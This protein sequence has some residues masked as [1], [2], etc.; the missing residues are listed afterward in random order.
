MKQINRPRARI[1]L[2]TVAVAALLGTAG[3]A[4]QN[5]APGAAA[6]GRQGGAATP[7]GR[8]AQAPNPADADVR[9]LHVQGNVWLI[10][11]GFVNAAVQIGDEGVLVVD[12]LTEPLGAK[13]GAEIKR[14]AGDNPIR[15]VLNTHFHADHTGGNLKVAGAGRSIVGGNFAGQVGAA[16]ADSAQIFAHENVQARMAQPESGETAPPFGA[17]PTDTFIETQKDFYFNGEPIEMLH[18]P[19]AHT[20]GDSI[21]YF[22]K[23]DVIVAGDVY[24]NTTF[25]VIDLKHGGN[26]NGIVKA[27]NTIIR[28]TVPKEKQEGGTYVIPGHGHLADEADVVEYRDMMTIIRDRFADA[29]K[30][31]MTLEQVKNARL[32]RDYEGRYG[33]A[34]GFWTTDAFVEAAYRSLSQKSPITGSR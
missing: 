13:L 32:V 24:I 22:R 16:A 12:T 11:A 25:P 15:Y 23:S 30:R 19:D 5:R 9:S 21:V 33:A 6:Q 2:A 7:A 3:T 20:D 10:N 29:V 31:G 34:Q 1:A 8:P 26:L 17:W 4:Q 28:I 18:Q 14:Q 27:L